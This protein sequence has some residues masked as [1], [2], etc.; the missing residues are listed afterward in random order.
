MSHGGV[1]F[2]TYE[3]CSLQYQFITWVMKDTD[4]KKRERPQL[5]F[6]W[7]FYIPLCKIIHQ[8]L[9]SLKWKHSLV[10][11]HHPVGVCG[12][13]RG[14]CWWEPESTER[15]Q[16]LKRNVAEVCAGWC[17]KSAGIL[18]YRHLTRTNA[19]PPPTSLSK[20]VLGKEVWSPSVLIEKKA[21]PTQGCLQLQ[22]LT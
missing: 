14:S 15:L 4:Q 10:F 8:Q 22:Y 7:S 17:F 12:L 18:S 11:P 5:K 2:I 13:A 20:D 1:L 21:L 19:Y 6:L 9:K 3:N 16:C